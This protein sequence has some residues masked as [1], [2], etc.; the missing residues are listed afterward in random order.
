[1]NAQ[2]SIHDCKRS[3]S[4]HETFWPRGGTL[5]SLGY[6][7]I[8]NPSI[9]ETPVAPRIRHHTFPFLLP[10]ALAKFHTLSRN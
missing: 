5:G 8:F 4:I 1:M 9:G 7:K 2:A 6:L 10:K 3:D